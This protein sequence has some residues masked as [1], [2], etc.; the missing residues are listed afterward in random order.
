MLPSKPT[1]SPSSRDKTTRSREAAPSRNRSSEISMTLPG[2]QSTARSMLGRASESSRAGE[3]NPEPNGPDRSCFPL[4]PGGHLMPK[5]NSRAMLRSSRKWKARYFLGSAARRRFERPP[6]V[7][8]TVAVSSCACR[9]L[10]ATPQHSVT[11]KCVSTISSPA[12]RNIA[13]IPCGR[14]RRQSGGR[15]WYRPSRL[16]LAPDT[17]PRSAHTVFDT[18]FTPT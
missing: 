6:A 4:A 9:G 15:G 1:D 8:P 10:R 3:W 11:S 16:A 18:P 12:N 7:Y 2:Q 13:S 5:R 14:I 17:G